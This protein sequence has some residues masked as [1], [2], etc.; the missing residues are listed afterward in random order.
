[1]VEVGVGNE[2]ELLKEGAPGPGFVLFCL[3]PR[4][5]DASLAELTK[6]YLD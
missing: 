4:A 5:V 1:M 6:H 3:R 2:L